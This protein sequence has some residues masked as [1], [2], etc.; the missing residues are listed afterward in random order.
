[1]SNFSGRNKTV[2]MNMN[3]GLKDSDHCDW[4]NGSVCRGAYHQAK[5]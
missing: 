3:E 5:I 1:M 2:M 4:Q